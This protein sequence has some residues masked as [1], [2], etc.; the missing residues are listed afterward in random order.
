M[1]LES[2]VKLRQSILRPADSSSP[3]GGG[4][5]EDDITGATTNE[6]FPMLAA[7]ASGDLGVDHA[8]QFQAACYHNL[9]E[10]NNL[11]NSL[12]WCRNL[13]SVPGA[14]GTS[15]FVSSSSDDDNTKKMRTWLK[16]GSA[17]IVEDVIL[18]GTSQVS[19][20][21]NLSECYLSRVL[22]VSS[23]VATNLVGELTQSVGS[24]PEEIGR[25]PA[26]MG[27]ASGELEFAASASL[28]DTVEVANRHTSPGLTFTRPRNSSSAL[29]T[30]TIEAE[31]YR[32]IWG[33][34]RRQPGMPALGQVDLKFRLEGD[35]D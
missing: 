25:I 16:V 20:F 27:W 11:L 1:I 24:G 6:W 14:A 29:D 30:G 8:E 28:N 22:L 19:G 17:L 32:K 31:S 15:K 35:S 4:S 7:P 10:T 18:N 13:L 33:R 21:Q 2:E 34:H 9:S 26:G 5:T 23:D 12:F 3:A